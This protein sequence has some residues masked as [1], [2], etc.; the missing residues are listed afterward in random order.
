MSRPSL[1]LPDLLCG[2]GSLLFESHEAQH[3]SQVRRREEL[4]RVLA[5]SLSNSEQR[6]R[7]AHLQGRLRELLLLLDVA[8]PGVVVVDRIC[9]RVVDRAQAVKRSL[10]LREDGEY[11]RRF[12]ATE[13]LDEG[14]RGHALFGLMQRDIAG[15]LDLD[16]VVRAIHHHVALLRQRLY[17]LER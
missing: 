9:E 8:D 11:L 14:T 1:A 3:K 2:L 6:R 10:E 12:A 13:D 5:S 16:A 17:L 15:M 4:T 7:A